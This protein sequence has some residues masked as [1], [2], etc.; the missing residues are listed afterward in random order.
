MIFSVKTPVF[1]GPLELLLSLIEKRKLLINDVTLANIADEYLE[2]VKTLSEFPTKDVS[3]FVL[4]ASTLVLIKSKSLLPEFTLTVEE[5]SDI[6]DLQDRLRLYK[7]VRE[8]A[9]GISIRFGRDVLFAREETSLTFEP[10]FAPHSSITKDRILESL[11]NVISRFPKTETLKKTIVEK[12][13]SI[14]E[15]MDRLT[16]RIKQ[17]LTMRF[18][19]FTMLHSDKNSSLRETKINTIISFL[20][21]LELV[22]QGLLAAHQNSTFSDIEI[23]TATVNTPRYI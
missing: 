13:V 2:H 5:E 9:G 7:K 19:D 8:L 23:E 4:I 12:I 1:E 17:A 14:E 20:A 22:K 18:S 16:V 6:V 3:H 10:V 11:A 15:M 21:M